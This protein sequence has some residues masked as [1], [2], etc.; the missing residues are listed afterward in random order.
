MKY[1]FLT[2]FVVFTFAI[3][4]P[5]ELRANPQID[6]ILKELPKLSGTPKVSALGRLGQLY[7]Y[8]DYQTALY[9]AR[10]AT[11][12]AERIQDKFYH[13]RMIANVGAVQY[14]LL[15]FKHALD[16]FK[17]SNKMFQEIGYLPGQVFCNS[18]IA[19]I[20]SR[21]GLNAD[22]AEY[23]T[24]AL[25]FYTINEVLDS[26][27]YYNTLKDGPDE[28]Q[29][30]FINIYAIA[31]ND[32]GLMK[33]SLGYIDDAIKYYNMALELGRAINRDERVGAALANIG[34]AYLRSDK[35]QLA[36]QY[37]LESVEIFRKIN[38]QL[39]LGN[40]I[41]NLA[42]VFIKLKDYRNAR[43]YA[44]NALKVYQNL[45]DSSNAIFNLLA[46]IERNDKNYSK[47]FAYLFKAQEIFIIT[48]NTPNLLLTYNDLANLYEETG[49]YKMA[50]LFRKKYIQLN[51]STFKT[52]RVTE[53]NNLLAFYEADKKDK[54]LQLLNRNI[55]LTTSELKRKL[56][57][58]VFIVVAGFFLVVLFALFVIMRI[59]TK[60]KEDIENKNKLL[61]KVN[62]ELQEINAT[63]DKFFSIIAH[64]IKNPL[65]SIKQVTEIMVDENIELDEEDKKDFNN[66]LNKSAVGLLNLLDSLLTWARTQTGK[67]TLHKE[68]INYFDLAN[69]CADLLEEQASNKNIK[70][71][72]D[73]N[74]R[75][76]LFADYN[77]I[78]T[79]I[80]NLISNAIKYTNTNGNIYVRSSISEDNNYAIIEVEDT[81][82]GMSPEILDRLFKLDKNRSK[83]GTNNEEGTGLGLLICKEFIEKNNGS[84]SVASTEGQGSTFKVTVPLYKVELVPND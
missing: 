19:A 80:C 43:N 3:S 57:S 34:M 75:I 7:F 29:R 17:L 62:S 40:T 39:Y 65:A 51:D 58:L 74:K 81:G 23:F 52:E 26:V 72:L 44:E 25:S 66:S 4:T 82:I 11:L 60:N 30:R 64:D 41:A 18:H 56:Q 83:L 35:Y 73:E 38:H 84:I 48:N 69:S 12:E 61:E 70:I 27:K 32:F 16:T 2:I 6:S 54:E 45:A 47:A 9:Y 49:D 46:D 20:Y 50:A 71:V 42:D 79:V 21:L 5:I 8:M 77:M 24:K 68:Y 53:M 22:A 14:R 1:L 15:I 78:D 33:Q 28:H 59:R 76:L 37:L 13:A 67:F 36:K 31:I 55:E 10:Q 63:K